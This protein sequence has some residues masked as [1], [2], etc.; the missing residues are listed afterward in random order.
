MLLTWFAVGRGTDSR[1]MGC[2][3]QPHCMHLSSALESNEPPLR[4]A[5]E[6][7]EIDIQHRASSKEYKLESFSVWVA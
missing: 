5:L 6:V 2:L 3:Q 1:L 7:L 4:I